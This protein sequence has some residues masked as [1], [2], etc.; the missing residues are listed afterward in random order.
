MWHF[1]DQ[2]YHDDLDRINMVSAAELQHVGRC[3]LATSLILTSGKAEYAK[4]ALDEL[5]GIAERRIDAEGALSRA[6]LASNPAD[7]T[8]RTIIEA[9]RDYYVTALSKVPDMT[10]PHQDLTAEVTAAQARVTRKGDAV[11]ETLKR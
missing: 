11:L 9:W 3:A 6:A 8:Q 7:S 1:T 2:H 10:L 5:A 4:A